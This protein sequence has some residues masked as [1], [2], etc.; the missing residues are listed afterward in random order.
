LG[1]NHAGTLSL[2]EDERGL[3]IEIIP[4]NTTWAKD[5]MESIRRGDVD[6]MSFGF[7]TKQDEWDE[8]DPKSSSRE[9]NLKYI[10]LRKLPLLPIANRIILRIELLMMLI[11]RI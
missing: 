7:R 6:Q 3:K 10:Y 11:I 1:R 9:A 8:R 5:L 2:V 4:P